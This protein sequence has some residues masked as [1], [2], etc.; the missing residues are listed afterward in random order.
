MKRLVFTTILIVAFYLPAV[1]FG[2]TP[3][4]NKSTVIYRDGLVT[5]KGGNTPV[6]NLLEDLSQKAGIHIFIFDPIDENPTQTQIDQKDLEN[7]LSILLKGCSY[8]VLYHS[9]E[10]RKGDKE[11]DFIS[12]PKVSGPGITLRTDFAFTDLKKGNTPGNNGREKD[13]ASKSDKGRR[14]SA[15]GYGRGVS[16]RKNALLPRRRQQNERRSPKGAQHRS[17]AGTKVSSANIQ[18]LS[19]T[20]DLLHKDMV[21]DVKENEARTDSNSH[22]GLTPAVEVSM[23]GAS[24]AQDSSIK[25]P[26]TSSVPKPS[27]PYSWRN[28]EQYLKRQIAVLEKRIESGQSDEEYERWVS[29]RGERYITHDK[30][31]LEFLRKRLALFE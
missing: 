20:D 5:I 24:P 6:L 11:G 22:Y 18:A 28:T 4:G 31:K 10:L 7:T 15:A 1:G 3:L 27:T 2:S 25:E 30:E 8:A 19:N 26:P 13:L 21:D 9:L 14:I 17:Q 12:E 16:P 29:V 23:D